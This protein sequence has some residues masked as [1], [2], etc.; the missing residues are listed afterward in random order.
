MDFA[1]FVEG[2]LP[3]R[4]ISGLWQIDARML[5][6]RSRPAAEGLPWVGFFANRGSAALRH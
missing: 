2:D 3:Q 1:S 4:L 6:V 5:D